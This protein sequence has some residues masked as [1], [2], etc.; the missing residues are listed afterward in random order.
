MITEHG[1]ERLVPEWMFHADAF[2]SNPIDLPLIHLDA[3]RHLIRIVVSSG[4]CS[5]EQ[6]QEGQCDAATQPVYATSRAT[7]TTTRRGAKTTCAI[8]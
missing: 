7:Q 6:G 2:D 5:V 3:L 4:L 8:C 1:G